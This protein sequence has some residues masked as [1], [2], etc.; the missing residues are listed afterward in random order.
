M[1]QARI[2][3]F[4]KK[5]IR[6]SALDWKAPTQAKAW[7]E[8]QRVL[9]NEAPKWLTLWANGLSCAVGIGENYDK[10]YVYEYSENSNTSFLLTIG[11]AERILLRTLKDL[12][13]ER[14]Q[15]DKKELN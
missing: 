15:T 12:Y 11:E 4:N 3:F 2:T 5:G 13:I 1:K 14:Y 8:G 7:E 10:F 6:I 9:Q